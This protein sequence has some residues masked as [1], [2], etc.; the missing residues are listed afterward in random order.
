[1][2]RT[3]VVTEAERPVRAGDIRPRKKLRPPC[4]GPVQ[5]F[6]F[7][8]GLR[9]C[10][11]W[12]RGRGE[13]SGRRCARSCRLGTFRCLGELLRWFCVIAAAARCEQDRG[14]YIRE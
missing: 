3:R 7:S 4:G 10:I 6:G 1:M 9:Q 2:P 14:E 13:R 12:P 5:E 11:L 8:D